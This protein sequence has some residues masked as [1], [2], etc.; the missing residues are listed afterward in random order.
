[1]IIMHFLPTCTENSDYDPSMVPNQILFNVS[2]NGTEQCFDVMIIDDN[3]SEDTENF[4]LTF[5]TPL[6]SEAENPRV[7]LTPRMFDVEITDN[8]EGNNTS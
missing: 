7:T 2:N 5:G 4:M 8:D 6:D 3:S 1:M